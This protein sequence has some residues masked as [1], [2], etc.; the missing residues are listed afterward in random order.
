MSRARGTVTGKAKGVGPYISNAGD[1]LCASEVLI[2]SI[3]SALAGIVYEVLDNLAQSSSFL[4]EVDHYTAA[5]VLCFADCFT[6][7]EG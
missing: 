7:T 5:A 3:A 2:G 4:T 1:V 6:N